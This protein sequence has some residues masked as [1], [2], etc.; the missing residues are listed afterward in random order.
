ML[1]K[2]VNDMNKHV[3]K[4]V[5]SVIPIAHV[6]GDMSQTPDIPIPRG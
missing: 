2:G 3:N 4:R 1:I 5:Q 6:V